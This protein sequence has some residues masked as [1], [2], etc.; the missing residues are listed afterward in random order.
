MLRIT[1]CRQLCNPSLCHGSPF[2][3]NY[4]TAWTG[5]EL[6]TL[7]P[8]EQAYNNNA[9]PMSSENQVEATNSQ[10]EESPDG[11]SQR[12][13]IPQS[14]SAPAVDESST[15]ATSQPKVCYTLN[16][17]SSSSDVVNIK[18]GDIIDGGVRLA[19]PRHM[20]TIAYYTASARLY[21]Y[22]NPLLISFPHN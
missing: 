10:Q 8:V 21:S 14:S 5:F 11:T 19:I 13:L 17:G 9:L 16:D 1:G 7:L 15:A 20:G 12:R 3:Q 2:Y 4:V 22:F 6:F 18:P